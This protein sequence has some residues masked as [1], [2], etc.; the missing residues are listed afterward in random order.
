VLTACREQSPSHCQNLFSVGD[1]GG[2]LISN[3]G[4]AENDVLVG[5]TS[6]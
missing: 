5:S 1:S 2:P 6:W 3:G 4:D